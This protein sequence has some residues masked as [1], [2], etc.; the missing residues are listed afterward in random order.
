MPGHGLGDQAG[1]IGEV[2]DPG[3]RREAGHP[4][5]D[6]DGDGHG[7]QTVGDA[8]RAD[9]LLAEHALGERHPLVVRPARQPADA[10][11]GEDEA[12]ARE[13]LVEVGGGGH[14]GGVGDTGGLLPQYTGHRIQST[15]VQVV[16]DDLGD[17]PFPAVGQQG[18]VHERHP[19]SAA[20]QNRQLHVCSL[21]GTPATTTSAPA[22]RRADRVTGS[23]G[24]S[25]TRVLARSSAGHLGERGMPSP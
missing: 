2:D 16:Q 18:T 7:A 10:D 14:P 23:G 1:R 13:R 8:A 4:P 24:A 11:R 17:P 20:A 9:G 15:V 3:V 12:G 5:G 21:P 19:E 6:V 25:V 22:C